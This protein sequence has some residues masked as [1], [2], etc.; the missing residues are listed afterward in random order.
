MGKKTRKR[1]YRISRIA[2]LGCFLLTACAAFMTKVEEPKYTVVATKGDMEIRN[3]SPMIVAETLVKAPESEAM[4]NG[5]RILADYLFGNNSE[6]KK[7]A[8]TAPVTR[9]GAAKDTWRVRFFMPSEYRLKTIPQP[10]NS[11]VQIK[12]VPYT[13]VAAIRFSGLVL[14][15]TV[16][17][18]TALLKDFIHSKGMVEQENPILARY[19]PPWTLP[20][21]RRNEVL[22]PVR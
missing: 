9:Q 4:S 19:D 2:V 18:K 11:D 15:R 5:F 3:Y 14:D 1:V 22:F 20:F 13:K 7:M 10:V 8:M 17:E 12:S 6:K 16:D 21:L